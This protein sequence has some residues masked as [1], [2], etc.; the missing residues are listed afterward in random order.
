MEVPLVLSD[1]PYSCSSLPGCIIPTPA[2][3]K[4]RPASNIPT[5]V[6]PPMRAVPITATRDA[7]RQSARGQISAS[8]LTNEHA[9]APPIP[10]GLGIRLPSCQYS[11]IQEQ[12]TRIGPSQKVAHA[13]IG[14]MQNTS[15]TSV[16][17]DNPVRAHSGRCPES[18][19][20][21]WAHQLCLPQSQNLL[22]ELLV[23]R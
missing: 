22:A 4:N 2:P 13:A 6:A 21:D 12:L 10:I 20:I 14:H 15:W 11:S 3:R 8:P 9:T 7:T 5:L 23:L 16:Q 1:V 19:E 17:L 18:I